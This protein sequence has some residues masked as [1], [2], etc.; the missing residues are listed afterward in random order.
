MPF[1]EFKPTVAPF[2]I[3]KEEEGP[4]IQLF[5]VKYQHLINPRNQSAFR[6]LVLSS[7]DSAN[8]VAITKN[9][10]L[11]LVEQFRLG[12]RTVCWELPGGFCESEERAIESAQREL[13]EETGYG[14][15]TWK[16]L[17]FSYSNPVFQDAKVH[18]V[19]AENVEWL[20]ETELDSGEDI[21]VHLLPLDQLNTANQAG[22]FKHPH[23]G[24]ALTLAFPFK[25]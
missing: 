6:A 25:V 19:L 4:D 15:G 21:T 7:R 16:Y 9:R 24:A 12:S 17:G 14:G 11:V 1:S 13:I 18:H 5:Q 8:V 22:T 20:Q 23:T 3:D 10:E 2:P